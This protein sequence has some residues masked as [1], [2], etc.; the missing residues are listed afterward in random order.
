MRILFISDNFPPE[1]NAPA[2]RTYEHCLEW[3]KLGADVTVITCFPNFPHGKLYSGY[4]NHFIKKET[5]DGIHVI[6][7]WSYMAPNRGL[8]KRLI[9]YMS[10]ACTSFLAGLSQKSDLIIATSPQLFASVSGYLLSVFK[11]KPWVFELRDLWP[12]SIKCLGAVRRGHLLDVLEKLELFL[13]RKAA[14]VVP[15]THAF[16]GNLVKRGID[17]QKIRVVTNGSNLDLFFARGK[18]PQLLRR[19]GLENK[20][21]V[22][23]IGTIG[24]AHGIDFIIRAVAK[25]RDPS[26]HFLIIGDG[27]NK[28]MVKNLAYQLGL[29]NVLFLDPVAKDEVPDCLSVIDVALIPLKKSETF[30]TVIP[31]KIFESAAMDKPMLLGVDGEAKQLIEMYKAG[32]CFEPENEVDFIEKLKLLRDRTFYQQLQR[33]CYRLA[34]DY[35]RKDLARKMLSILEEAAG[36]SRPAPATLRDEEIRLPVN[37]QAAEL[38]HSD[39][40]KAIETPE[41]VAKP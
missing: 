25:I 2:T 9:D 33:G 8:I 35:N 6:R 29:E 5:M 30:K 13:Y 10:F 41:R 17:A 32:I 22:G 15:N 23:Y 12:D 37:L 1:V 20:F 34:R 26:V 38:P 11:R 21:V 27:A 7:V 36:V 3:V 14:V 19:Y 39:V 24:M 28:E 40:L 4:R 18:N 31:S 16:K